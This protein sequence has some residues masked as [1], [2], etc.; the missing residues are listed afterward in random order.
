M[1]GNE[2]TEPADPRARRPPAS[3]G[4]RRTPS[5]PSSDLAKLL[6]KQRERY[7]RQELAREHSGAA[8]SSSAEEPPGP[9][10][11]AN[12]V[13]AYNLTRARQLRGWS[14]EEAARRLAPHL[15]VEWSKALFSA[16]ERSVDGNRI[17]PFD[18]DELVAFSRTFDLP[19]GYF[20]LPPTP[21]EKTPVIPGWYAIGPREARDGAELSQPLTAVELAERM[22]LAGFD[23]FLAE[24]EARVSILGE[25]TQLREGLWNHFLRYYVDAISSGG[26]FGAS[27]ELHRIAN[28]LEPIEREMKNAFAQAAAHRFSRWDDDDEPPADHPMFEQEEDAD[29]DQPVAEESPGSEESR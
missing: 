24:F 18:A 29:A 20:F 17:R 19:I 11:T 28:G 12:Q 23:E 21:V 26:V 7:R 27:A 2:G 25:R 1:A 14:Q 3:P 15:G 5:Q 22:L 16:A 10:L 6:A 4:G 8:A 13:V 9:R